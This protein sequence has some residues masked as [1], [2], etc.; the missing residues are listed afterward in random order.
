[1]ARSCSNKGG[2]GYGRPVKGLPYAV[3]NISFQLRQTVQEL[4]ETLQASVYTV[5]VPGIA[6]LVLVTVMVFGVWR[7]KRKLY[8]LTAA[9]LH[10]RAL[11]RLMKQEQQQQQ[12]QQR[13]E[14]SS[15]KKNQY[16]QVLQLL[17]KAIEQ[18]PTY[19]PA[20]LSLAALYIYRLSDGLA[21]AQILH[22][23]EIADGHEHSVAEEEQV[24]GLL[25]DAQAII[26]GQ[27][28]MVQAALQEDRYLSTTPGPA[29]TRSIRIVTSKSKSNRKND[30]TIQRKTQ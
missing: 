3:Q 13:A 19:L 21:A 30:V 5:I 7:I 29:A 8:P 25:L 18:D 6:V 20:R 24:Q 9:E 15:K 17:T 16:Q 11:L 27:G 2:Q 22:Q 1:M 26:S 10:R 4:W 23:N 12:K 14:D 28:H